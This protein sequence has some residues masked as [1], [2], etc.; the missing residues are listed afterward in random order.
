MPPFTARVR[1]FDVNPYVAPPRKVLEDLFRQ[2]GRDRS[3]IPVRGTLNGV[4]FVQTLVRY[5]GAWRLYL[6]TAMRRA[7]GLDVGDDVRVDVRFDARPRVYPVPAALKRALGVRPADAKAFRAL[8]P[9][10]RRE[11]ARYI[12]SLKNEASIA[13]N[14]AKV[15]RVLKARRALQS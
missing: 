3:P 7:T 13:R 9:Y 12:G 15:L 5:A 10:R 11:I 8:P 6:N 1:K 2:S 14:V 4:P